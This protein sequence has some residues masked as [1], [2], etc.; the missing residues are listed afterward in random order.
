[1]TCQGCKNR[2]PGCH[3]TCEAYIEWKE[4]YS[5]EC[6][7]IKKLKEYDNDFISEKCRSV[8]RATGRKARRQ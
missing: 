1:M 2:Y 8:E 3:A 5:I 6:E 4:H 7:R